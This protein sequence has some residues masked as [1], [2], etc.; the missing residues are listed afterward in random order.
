MGFPDRQEEEEGE[1]EGDNP[2]TDA[3]ALQ[4]ILHMLQPGGSVEGQTIPPGMT[5]KQLLQSVQ[6][7]MAA[8]VGSDVLFLDL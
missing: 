8:Q 2:E 4:H 7:A 5:A 3:A 1:E 6:A